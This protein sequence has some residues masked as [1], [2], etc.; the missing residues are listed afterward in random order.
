[1]KKRILLS[2][3]VAGGA[4]A[5]Y[6]IRRLEEKVQKTEE[7]DVTFVKIDED[8]AEYSNEVDQISELYPYLSKKFIE[9]VFSQ[10]DKLNEDYPDETLVEIKHY[11][12]FGEESDVNHFVRLMQAAGYEL[13]SNEEGN[14]FIV[15]KKFYN[16][17]GR[18]ISEI[19]NVANQVNNLGGLYTG[20]EINEQ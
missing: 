6:L 8:E 3:L 18:L 5:Y 10:N 13:N 14:D 2:L 16:E 12:S 1:M 4:A 19:Y 7:E 17:K 15:I 11:A 20:Y 9:K